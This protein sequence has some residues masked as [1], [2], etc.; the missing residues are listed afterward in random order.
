MIIEEST[1]GD[2][3]LLERELA[4]L[5][6]ANLNGWIYNPFLRTYT[7][8]SPYTDLKII[9]NL[10]FDVSGESLQIQKD[11]LYAF[12]PSLGGRTSFPNG[13]KSFG[14][15]LKIFRINEP[16]QNT[17]TDPSILNIQILYNGFFD[18]SIQGIPEVGLTSGGRFAVFQEGFSGSYGAYILIE[19]A[20]TTLDA[21]VFRFGPGV[22]FVT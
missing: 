6:N 12:G 19:N 14:F 5:Y 4:S 9:Y 22:Y 18:Y 3:F 7:K 11:K 1:D 8:L 15:T 21:S 16:Y 10:G 17:I 20:G 2:P 13:L